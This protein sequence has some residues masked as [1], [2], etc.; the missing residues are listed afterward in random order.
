MIYFAHE[1]ADSAKNMRRFFPLEHWAIW[2][3]GTDCLEPELLIKLSRRSHPTPD[4]IDNQ[5]GYILVLYLLL[6]GMETANIK[7]EWKFIDV[8]V[9]I[10]LSL[11][12]SVLFRFLALKW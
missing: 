2:K 9:S 6:V 10:C 7:I 4:V 1:W 5:L 8:R 12:Q 3:W 11:G